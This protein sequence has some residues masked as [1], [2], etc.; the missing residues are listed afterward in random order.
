VLA[1]IAA[2]EVGIRI[3]DV[4]VITGDTST[5]PQ[6]LGAWGSREVFIAGNAAKMAAGELK[7][8]LFEAAS[9]ILGG[10]VEDLIAR[11][12][13]VY[14]KQNP[15]KSVSTAQVAMTC[16]NRGRILAGRGC[17]DDPSSFAPDPK[18]GYGGAPTYGFGT[19]AVE[20]EVDKKTGQVKVLNYIAAHDL[21][22]AIN[23]MMAGRPN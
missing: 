12:R 21:G 13:R 4:N 22:K 2:E 15:E 8:R 17:Y 20:V 10:P 5:T 14:V 11:D 19:H 6:D 3:E 16:Y 23:P 18:T 1:Q 7:Q 9:P